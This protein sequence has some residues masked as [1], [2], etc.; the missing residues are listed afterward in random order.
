MSAVVVDPISL[1]TCSEGPVPAHHD[2]CCTAMEELPPCPN[3][4]TN[5]V[6]DLP[7]EHEV[8]AVEG[9]VSSAPDLRTSPRA[10]FL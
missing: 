1:R 2:E 6:P 3:D 7:A 4:H 5:L 8:L 9:Q 10:L